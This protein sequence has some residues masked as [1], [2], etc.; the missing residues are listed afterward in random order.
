M[1]RVEGRLTES[2]LTIRPATSADSAAWQELGDETVPQGGSYI[3]W[4]GDGAIARV[5]L[6]QFDNVLDLGEFAVAEEQRA[7]HGAA[8]LQQIVALCRER[9]N[10][11]TVNYPPHYSDL[12]LNA[13]FKQNTRT[14]MI[15]ALDDYQPLPV[16]LPAGVT[17]RYPTLSDETAITNMAYRNYQGTPDGEMVS[18]SRAQTDALMQPIFANEYATLDLDCSFIAE[19][20]AGNLV[21]SSLLGDESKSEVDRL[22]W[23]LDISTAPEWRGKG[24]GRALFASG[25]AAAKAKGYHR[26]GLMV[27]IGNQGA[28]AL[29]RS[30]GLREY[31][32]LMYEAVL[33]L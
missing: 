3:V 5:T 24:L 29:Y 2:S 16:R 31:G 30:F 18:S 11:I 21:G 13:Y 25:L 6:H 28:Q 17:L 23:V 12:F 10:L 20:A 9:G 14:R 8:A 33:R 32:P 26:L 15:R 4:L 1:M 22:A 7:E 19:D 27:T